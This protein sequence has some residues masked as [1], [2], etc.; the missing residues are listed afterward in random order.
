MRCA[1]GCCGHAP[2][3][4][5]GQEQGQGLGQDLQLL[6]APCSPDSA[7]DVGHYAVWS[8]VALRLPAA[9]SEVRE[10]HVPQQ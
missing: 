6:A 10:R 7:D 8:C 5:P 4:S 9:A 1:R 2:G 3:L